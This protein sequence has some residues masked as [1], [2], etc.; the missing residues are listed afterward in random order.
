SATVTG[1]PAC[2]AQ[3]ASLVSLW[4]GN[5]NANDVGPGGYNGTLE[6]GVTYALGEVGDAFSFSGSDQYVLIGQP[7]PTNLQIQGAISMS[8]WVY[9]TALPTSYATIMGSEDGNDGIGLYIDNA[10][11]RTDVPPGAIDFDI[12]NGSGFYSVLT[13]TQVPLNQWTLVTVTASANNPSLV[14]FNGVQ[15]PTITPSGET[16][17]TTSTTVPYNASG[18]WFAIGQSSAS[19]WPFTG[20]LNDV[21]VYNAALTSAQVQAIYNAGSGG[22]CQ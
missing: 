11:N 20:L 16:P 14:Y 3:P 6:N 5:D 15:Q 4:P 9:M 22:V 21:A 1:A 18:Q 17:W 8:A 7:V 12:G 10:N 19:N 13:T 2:L